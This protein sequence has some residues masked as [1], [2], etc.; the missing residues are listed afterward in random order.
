MAKRIKSFWVK[1]V[2]D[3]KLKAERVALL[4]NEL[5]V[6][7]LYS[8]LKEMK[9]K[10]LESYGASNDYSVPNWQYAVA[11]NNGKLAVIEELLSL[12]DF[13]Q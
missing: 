7:M 5:G 12:L 4:E 13:K 10:T 9:Q 8:Y 6:E 1:G 2:T 3:T 11:E